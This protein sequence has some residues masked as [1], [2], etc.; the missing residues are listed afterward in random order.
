VTWQDRKVT[1]YVDGKLIGQTVVPPEKH[2]RGVPPSFYLG[3]MANW[4]PQQKKAYTAFEDFV[5]FS[6]ALSPEEIV[7]ETNRQGAL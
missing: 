3:Q 7:R 5:I 6:R 1:L 4:D 2:F